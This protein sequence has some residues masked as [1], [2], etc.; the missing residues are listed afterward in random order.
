MAE[1]EKEEVGRQLGT[2][3]PPLKCSGLAAHCGP[4]A[5]S[6]PAFQMLAAEQE[7]TSGLCQDFFPEELAGSSMHGSNPRAASRSNGIFLPSQNLGV[8][9]HFILLV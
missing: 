4:S 3:E 5:E 2:S 9:S 1:L 8:G 7:V 6:L